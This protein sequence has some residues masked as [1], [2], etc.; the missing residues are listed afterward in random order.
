MEMNTVTKTLLIPALLLC[1]SACDKF[2]PKSEYDYYQQANNYLQANER[3]KA[4]AH[5]K[6]GIGKYPSSSFLKNELFDFYRKTNRDEAEKYLEVASLESRQF[7]NA[8]SSLANDYF[9]EKKYQ[10]ALKY[11]MMQGEA[12]FNSAPRSGGVCSKNG[13]AIEAYRNAA[14]SASNIGDRTSIRTAFERMQGISKSASCPDSTSSA[15]LVEVQSW[16]RQ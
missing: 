2:L 3:S 4:E 10:K 15:Y 5:L 6:E 7:T 9:I 12:E 1:L 13:V 16:V 8:C 11:Y 14:A